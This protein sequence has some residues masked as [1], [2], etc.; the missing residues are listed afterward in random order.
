MRAEYV[1]HENNKSQLEQIIH[2]VVDFL[3]PSDFYKPLEFLRAN[4]E[5]LRD[6]TCSPLA[7]YELMHE[8][9]KV[10]TY[11]RDCFF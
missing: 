9:M 8:A 1:Y 3:C 10:Q 7:S 11:L 2:Q 6:G 5:L 4:L